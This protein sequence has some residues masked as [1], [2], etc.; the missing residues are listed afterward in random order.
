MLGLRL[1]TAGIVIAFLV[2][3][4]LFFGVQGIALCI[5]FF[6]GIALWELASCLPALK[7]LPGRVLTILFGLAVTAAF[8]LLPSNM[9]IAA[10]VWLPLL[11]LLVHLALYHRI[12]RSVESASQMVTAVAYVMVPLCHAILLRKLDF[13]TAWVFFVLLVT[14][15]GDTGAYLAGRYYGK[16]HFSSAVSPSKTIEGLMGGLG[17]NLF[18]ML[19][20][21]AAVPD[22]ASLK[23]LLI[24]TLILAVG[25]PVGDLAASM[26]KRKL[27]IKDFGSILPG[28]GG[29]MDRADSLIFAF[30][31]TYYFLL[32]AGQWGPR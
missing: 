13:G 30:P 23:T 20:V 26:I 6:G 4:L 11:I 21:K 7:P 32:F 1:L 17:G 3:L 25:G 5:A 16:H 2:P 8:L 12:E 15:L 10:V 14:C 24:L 31:I 18:G 27:G 28:H 22:I 19:L 29:V 9:A